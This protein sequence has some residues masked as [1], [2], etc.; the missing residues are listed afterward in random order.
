MTLKGVA[1]GLHAF[2]FPFSGRICRHTEE[3]CHLQEV[4]MMVLVMIMVM[5]II[6]M[7]TLMMMVR[8]TKTMNAQEKTK[9]LALLFN[10][11][12]N[13]QEKRQLFDFFV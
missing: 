1:V 3:D 8:I 13:A 4:I 12:Y 9:W 2:G 6:A 5:M 7:M 11:H 10:A